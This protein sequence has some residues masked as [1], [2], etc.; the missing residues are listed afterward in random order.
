MGAKSIGETHNHSKSAYHGVRVLLK[1]RLVILDGVHLEVLKIIICI[2]LPY[3]NRS[4]DVP[5]EILILSGDKETPAHERDLISVS[6]TVLK[7]LRTWMFR[8]S[9]GIHREIS[10]ISSLWTLLRC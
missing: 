2:L 3:A 5:I 4:R 1:T 6:T 9:R 8:R 10:F 7:I